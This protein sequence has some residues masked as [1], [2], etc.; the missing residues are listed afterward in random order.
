M[1][2]A[3]DRLSA[4]RYFSSMKSGAR[5]MKALPE[6]RMTADEFIFWAKRRV[7]RHHWRS[8]EGRIL[9]RLL[10]EGTLELDPPG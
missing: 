4:P 8:E 10:G 9:S 5:A 2:R 6:K 7:V 3:D 1:Y